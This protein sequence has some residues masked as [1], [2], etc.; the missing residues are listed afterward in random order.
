[1]LDTY[2]PPAE[3]PR[4]PL[5]DGPLGLYL[6]DGRRCG[7]ST[8]ASVRGKSRVCD[9]SVLPAGS[10]VAWDGRPRGRAA[11][12]PVEPHGS[13]RAPVSLHANAHTTRVGDPGLSHDGPRGVPARGTDSS[14]TEP[15]PRTADGSAWALA[16]DSPWALRS[17]IR[18]TDEHPPTVP[19]HRRDGHRQRGRLPASAA[20]NQQR[21]A[22]DARGA[23]RVRNRARDRTRDIT[24]HL[25]RG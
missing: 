2:R 24:I 23:T 4:L 15:N 9:E 25:R 6:N 8:G 14:H 10:R 19:D 1:M 22:A 12:G 7:I 17:R 3:M 20:S 5:N 18:C 21:R 11:R 16:L 13:A